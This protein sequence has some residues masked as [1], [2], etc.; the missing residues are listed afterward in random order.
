MKLP[1]ITQI[2]SLNEF[3]E[4]VLKNE[5]TIIKLGAKWCQPCKRI[6][7]LVNQWVDKLPDNIQMCYLDIDISFNL[8]SFLKTKRIVNGI[9]ALLCYNKTNV[10]EIIPNDVVIGAD[11]TQINLFFERCIKKII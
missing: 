4:I 2:K 3:K 7:P 6:D 10:F 11:P 1:I 9:P 8:Y 5:L